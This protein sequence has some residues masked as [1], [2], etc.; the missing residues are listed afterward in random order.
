MDPRQ[1]HGQQHQHQQPHPPGSNPFAR[2]PASPPAQGLGLGQPQ[3]QPQP[4]PQGQYGRSPFPPAASSSSSNP[5]PNPNSNPNSSSA[6]PSHYP[7]A[8]HPQSHPPPSTASPATSAYG[9]P[10]DHQRRPSSD[11]HSYYPHQPSRPPFAGPEPISHPAQTHSRHQSSSS[12]GGGPLNRNMGPPSEHPQ[13]QPMGSYGSQQSASGPRLPPP[14]L[15]P[16]SAFPSSRELPSLSGLARTGAAGMPLSNML[17]GHAAQREPTPGNHS[18]HPAFPPPASGPG[19]NGPGPGPGP[20]Y[21]T[22]VQ[23]SPRLQNAVA[24]Y[25]QFARRPDRPETPTNHAR[26]YDPRDQRGSA[27]GSPPQPYH[28][29]PELSTRYGTPQ[30]HQTRGPPMPPYDD[31][32][33]QSGRIS[34]GSLPPRP[35]SQ[36]RAYANSGPGR[37]MEMGRGPP[38]GEPYFGPRREE[39]RPGQA[40]YNPEGPPRHMFEDPRRAMEEREYRER[41]EREA[42]HREREHMERERLERAHFEE[43]QRLQHHQPPFMSERE[44]MERME[45]DRMDRDRQFDMQ[46][47]ERRARTSSDPNR[48]RPGDFVPQGPPGPPGPTPFGRDPRDPRDP[49]DA[50]GWQLRPGYEQAPPRGPYDPGYGPRSGPAEHVATAAPPYGPYPAHAL[51][52]GDRFPQ[53]GPPP[54]HAVPTNQPERRPQSFDSPDRHRFTT[55]MPVHH[56]QQHPSHRGRHEEDGPPPSGPYNGG[57]GAAMHEIQ[58]QQPRPLDDGHPA[59]PLARQPSS[60]FLAVG[61]M[62]RKGRISPLPQAVQGAQPQSITPSGEPGIKSEFGRM[63]S[64]IGSGASGFGMPSPGPAHLPFT[65]ASLARRD[66]VE[67]PPP[68]V[69]ADPPPKRKRQRKPKNEDKEG[70]DDSTGRQTPAGRTTKRARTSHASHAHHHHQYVPTGHPLQHSQFTDIALSSH[71]HHHH[72]GPERTASPLL[73][74]GTPLKNVKSGTPVLSPTGLPMT[75]NHQIPRSNNSVAPTKQVVQAPVV[76]PKTKKT[77]DSQLV[78]NS[79][80]HKPRKHLGDILYDPE[81]K[82]DHFRTH[83]KGGFRTKPKPLPRNVILD[84]EN[85]TLTVKVHRRHLEPHCREEVTRNRSVWGTDIYTDDSDVVAACIHAGWFRGEWQE[86][87]DIGLLDL[88]RQP[89]KTKGRG[90]MVAEKGPQDLLTAPPVTG[91]MHVPADRDL[92]VTILVLPNLVK[93][94][95]T[96][97]FGIMS[98]EFGGSYRGRKSVHDGLSFKIEQIRWVDGAAPQSRLRGKARRERIRKAMSEVDRSQVIDIGTGKKV[99]KSTENTSVSGDTDKENR[100]TAVESP[101]VVNG[102]RDVKDN[103]D[104]TQ[105]IREPSGDIDMQAMETEKPTTAEPEAVKAS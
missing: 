21:A 105:E 74:G 103:T 39:M 104:T 33:D 82:A 92:H 10:P 48:G 31:R 88:E 29:T 85:S 70:D 46:E 101:P 7:P 35:S 28:G 16:S 26:P 43:Q 91:P 5:N 79:V 15:G 6:T 42:H 76:V 97:R 60:G 34:A 61:E 1:H 102:N 19:P 100:L 77:I 12:I 90:G 11:S 55:H 57:P 17:G 83:S 36:P 44:H 66:D 87:V 65:N 54:S 62:N 94:T 52:P 98:R 30:A 32:R 20:A 27:A 73:A 81:I 63:F 14:S 22:A 38:P 41:A 49:R 86:G 80:A 3:P 24:E 25:P 9:G 51:A 99:E 13:Q 53:S 72:H 2:N 59:P 84:N 47:R 78:L 23:A 58:R 69:T 67:P 93:Y 18:A 71:H 50:P 68:E 40:E 37:P 89:P 64:G 4:Q 56:P 95:G 45:R 75:H 96:T 8:S